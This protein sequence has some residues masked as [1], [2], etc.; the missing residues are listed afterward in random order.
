M[1]DPFFDPF[2][3]LEQI[4]AWARTR[5]PHVV[6]FAAP[7]MRSRQ[8][9]TSLNVAVRSAHAALKAR[10]AGRDVD[11]ELWR[12]SG[13]PMP[14]NAYVAP[15][16]LERLANELGVP[17]F[18]IVN[19]ASLEVRFPR[20]ER[21]EAF[22]DAYAR[23]TEF[24]QEVLLNLFRRSRPEDERTWIDDP[25]FAS[26]SADLR[27]RLADYVNRK[28]VQ[29]PW[30]LLR[31]ETFPIE[32]YLLQLFRTE[33]LMAHANL[34][35]NP[36]ARALT[37]ADWGGLEIAV[38]GDRRRLSV[39][40][41]GRVCK[42]GEGDF[43]NV[44]VEREAVIREF[45]EGRPSPIQSTTALISDDVA[46][47]VIRE[48]LGEAGGYFSQEKGAEIVRAKYPAFGKK[49]AMQLVKELTGNEKPGPK[50]PRKNCAGNRAG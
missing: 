29:G 19:D 46:R 4:R 33:R 37:K 14:E 20:C 48:A 24:E 2:W 10:Q 32:D 3:D 18:Q 21:T 30:R 15:M 11:V 28:E 5:D 23:A 47:A 34:P 50:G 39:W 35:E 36:V 41:L 16:A 17:I 27:Q 49:R 43:Q 44:R 26:L 22:L 40:C 25:M 7:G 42:T 13:W 45:P 6:R 1:I 12:A 9:Q 38:G 31:H 8:P